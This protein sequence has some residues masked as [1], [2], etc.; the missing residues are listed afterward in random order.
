MSSRLDEAC[1]KYVYDVLHWM[2][3]HFKGYHV[4]VVVK[5]GLNNTTTHKV[6][7]VS[8]DSHCLG[9]VIWN[10]TL[11]TSRLIHKFWTPHNFI[12][13]VI[14]ANSMIEMTTT[15]NSRCGHLLL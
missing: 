2:P 6:I 14:L 13:A 9:G 10:Y 4:F 1:K 3:T 15:T 5:I 12:C 8:Y 7:H 11:S